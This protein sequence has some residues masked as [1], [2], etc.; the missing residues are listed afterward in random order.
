MAG[1]LAFDS[2]FT[3]LTPDQKILSDVQIQIIH[4]HSKDCTRVPWESLTYLLTVSSMTGNQVVS[5][6]FDFY[7]CNHMVRFVLLGD[8]I[9]YPGYHFL[10]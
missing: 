3:S 2:G 10:V 6:M 1:F 9:E 7:T 4:S 8:E 5:T